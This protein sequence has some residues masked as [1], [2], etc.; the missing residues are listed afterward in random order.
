MLFAV[1]TM[2]TMV[3]PPLQ[4]S[5]RKPARVREFSIFFASSPIKTTP[6][7]F[8][9]V[10]PP[11]IFAKPAPLLEPPKIKTLGWSKLLIAASVGSGFVAYES[12]SYKMLVLRLEN[13][14]EIN[15]ILYDI[16]PVHALLT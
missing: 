12:L 16:I 6:R 13:V 3:L 4:I 10:I 2:S 8:D 1:K 7:I 11:A 14:R 15:G 9:F 5:P